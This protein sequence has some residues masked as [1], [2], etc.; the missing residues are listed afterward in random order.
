MYAG[1]RLRTRLLRS[2]QIVTN[3]Q[4]QPSTPVSLRDSRPLPSGLGNDRDLGPLVPPVVPDLEVPP[5]PRVV[6][7]G[8]QDLVESVYDPIPPSSRPCVHSC[9]V[10]KCSRF[11]VHSGSGSTSRGQETSSLASTRFR[12]SR[13]LT[14]IPPPPRLGALCVSHSLPFGIPQSVR[15]CEVHRGRGH[16]FGPPVATPSSV[17][18]RRNDWTE[19]P[20][21]DLQCRPT[22]RCPEAR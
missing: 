7:E 11:S 4:S 1:R 13:G 16:R 20:R 19:V 6:S 15:S 21:R 9:V 8:D 22:K 2:S 3:L 18:T 5:R 14:V 12:R 17:P 10:R